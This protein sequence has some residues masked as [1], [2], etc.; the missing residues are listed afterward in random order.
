MSIWVLLFFAF[1]FHVNATFRH[2]AF[3]ITDEQIA[4]QTNPDDRAF[5]IREKEKKAREIEEE[6]AASE[7]NALI[8][9][10]LAGCL[11][12]WYARLR[13]H[14]KSASVGSGMTG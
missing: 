14:G 3:P 4:R 8:M 12:I 5:L 2:Q 9:L 1:Y 7:R 13:E 6:R 10:G 11:G